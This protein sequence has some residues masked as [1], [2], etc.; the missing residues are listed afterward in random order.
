MLPTVV[1]KTL[2]DLGIALPPFRDGLVRLE[3]TPEQEAD[4]RLVPD[5]CYEAL[6]QFWPHFTSGWLQW[7]LSRPNSCF[8]EEVITFPDGE[9]LVVPQSSEDYHRDLLPK[10]VWLLG[11]VTKELQESRQVVIYLRQTG[12][13]DIRQRLVDVLRTHAGIDAV[14]LS[15]SVEPRKREAWL[16]ARG[17]RVL[18]TNPR[19]CRNRAGFGGLR[20]CCMVRDQIIVSTLSG[21][22][23]GGCGVWGRQSR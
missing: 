11:C 20:N 5:E 2:A 14:V 12:T 21:K 9:R 13:R 6:R 17:P 8:R 7:T 16:K 3:M 18:I 1:F 15:E 19:L 22:P 10:E 4:Y 23:A